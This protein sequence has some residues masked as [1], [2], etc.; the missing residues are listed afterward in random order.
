MQLAA[1]SESYTKGFLVGR[2]SARG[3]LIPV[4]I[5]TQ[6]A[7]QYPN[8]GLGGSLQLLDWLDQVTFPEEKKHWDLEYAKGVYEQ[9]VRRTLD[10]GVCDPD[11]TLAKADHV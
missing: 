3:S 9:V 6:H 5:D 2:D 4:L 1:I 10:A 11:R 8:N 7:P